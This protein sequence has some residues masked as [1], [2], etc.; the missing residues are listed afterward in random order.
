MDVTIISQ[1]YARALFGLAIEM[2]VLEDV[3]NDIDL[4][5]KVTSENPQFRRLLM[6]PIISAG[7]KNSI[8]KGIF[9][10]KIN[11]LTFKFLQLVIRKERELYLKEIT[12]AFEKMY[13]DHH[14]ILKASVISAIPLD[15]ENRK[16]LLKI[17]EEQTHKTI[18]LEEK[19]DESLIGGFVVKM[20][21]RK[22]DAS[23]RYKLDRLRKSFEKNLYVK[24]F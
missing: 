18:L 4:I 9:D 21:D 6:S 5:A 8:I 19:T 23:L 14:N 20:D 3:K 10:K 2:K 11:K 12:E 1:R 7:K 17:L 22:Y 16:A 15:K 13:N 24:T